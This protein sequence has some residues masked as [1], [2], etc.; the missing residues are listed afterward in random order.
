M[1]DASTVVATHLNHLVVQHAAELLGRQE[2]QSLVE[3]TGK[4]AP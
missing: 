2:V 4:D 1:V 3:R